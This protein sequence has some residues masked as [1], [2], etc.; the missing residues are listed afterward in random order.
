MQDIA[1][2]G[3]GGFGRETALMLA[4]INREEP[5]WNVLGF[6]DDKMPTGTQVDGY[7]ILGNMD[8]INSFPEFLAVAVAVAEP[9]IRKALV[10]QFHNPRLHFPVLAHPAAN[11]GGER[12][13][14]GRG[15]IIT[16]GNILTTSVVLGEFVIVNLMCTLGHDVRIGSFSSLMPGC[17][18]SGNVLTG[19]C[20]MIGTGARILQ[21]IS[22]GA[23]SKIGAGAVV[24]A[25]VPI[26]TTVAG[27]PA[28]VIN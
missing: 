18:V 24:V 11:L 3:A 2:Y 28:K 14:F 23:F 13:F 15:T 16:A 4:Q 1:I 20:T 27:I 22:L 8:A 26:R 7:Q 21:N 6:F 12:N 5:T 25:D 9:K 10:Q 17:S 19:E